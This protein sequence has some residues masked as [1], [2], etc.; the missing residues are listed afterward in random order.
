M[1]GGKGEGEGGGGGGGKGEGEWGGGG[2]GGGGE[3]E[4]GREEKGEDRRR[5]MTRKYFAPYTIALFP[6]IT[7]LV[8]GFRRRH[9]KG[10]R[11]LADHSRSDLRIR[12][13][14]NSSGNCFHLELQ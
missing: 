1:G 12:V 11:M 8:S 13:V 10:Y 5:D 7:K 4:G 9:M 3:G 2:G 14:S 6:S